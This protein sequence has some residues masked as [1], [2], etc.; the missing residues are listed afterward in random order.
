VDDYERRRWP[1]YFV[2]SAAVL[3]HPYGTRPPVRAVRISIGSEPWAIRAVIQDESHT[4][5]QAC[6]VLEEL[7]RGVDHALTTGSPA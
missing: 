1:D 2:P 4:V 5:S 7:P 3:H 6:E